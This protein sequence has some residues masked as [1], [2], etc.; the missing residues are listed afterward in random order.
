MG[1]QDSQ[2]GTQSGHVTLISK[3]VNSINGVMVYM[4]RNNVKK[5]VALSYYL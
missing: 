5:T 4:S 2:A 1:P 3:P